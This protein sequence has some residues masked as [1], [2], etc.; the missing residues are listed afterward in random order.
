MKAKQSKNFVGKLGNK[1]P[2]IKTAKA[3]KTTKS[4]RVYNDGLMSVDTTYQRDT[5]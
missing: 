3:G 2:R 1:Q 5:R 4:G